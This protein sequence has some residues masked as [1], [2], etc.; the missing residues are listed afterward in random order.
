MPDLMDTGYEGEE[1]A[2]IGRVVL[3]DMAEGSP[4]DVAD[5]VVADAN[6]EGQV[7]ATRMVNLR[8]VGPV[9]AP[10]G[11]VLIGHHI[12]NALIGDDIDRFMKHVTEV[13]PPRRAVKG[14][15][16]FKATHAH[17]SVRAK[18]AMAA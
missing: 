10:I 6:D 3:L 4:V 5:A 1:Q 7:G 13:P 15:A 8:T 11:S 9:W 2:A 17:L 12:R 16:A 18:L 14:G